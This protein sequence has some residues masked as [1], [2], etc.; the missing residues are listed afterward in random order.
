[1]VM[2]S[3]RLGTTSLVQDWSRIADGPSI[4]CFFRTTAEHGNSTFTS[5]PS[6]HIQVSG[7]RENR[8]M[9]GLSSVHEVVTS[10]LNFRVSGLHVPTLRSSS[11][12][13]MAELPK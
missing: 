11:D 9:K 13:Y 1:M 4:V 3:N 2:V 7:A 5:V 10:L 12:I 6:Q 8:Y